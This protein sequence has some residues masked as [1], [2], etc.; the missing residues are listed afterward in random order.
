[1]QHNIYNWKLT[2]PLQK[3]I[4]Q[5]IVIFL[6]P[7]SRSGCLCDIYSCSSNSLLWTFSISGLVNLTTNTPAYTLLKSSHCFKI[8]LRAG[9][10]EKQNWLLVHKINQ[11]LLLVRKNKDS[12]ITVAR[13]PYAANLT[14]CPCSVSG[15]TFLVDCPLWSHPTRTLGKSAFLHSTSCRYK[16]GGFTMALVLVGFYG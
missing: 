5:R 3:E 8:S 13:I 11:I 16:F 14:G 12:A 2:H 7:D 15:N 9:E 6:E 1:M 10:I 4:T